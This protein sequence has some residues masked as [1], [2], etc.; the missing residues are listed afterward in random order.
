MERNVKKSKR[1]T[2]KMVKTAIISAFS[3]IKQ[4][5]LTLEYPSILKAKKDNPSLIDFQIIGYR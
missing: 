3:T 2:A 1:G 4:C 5:R